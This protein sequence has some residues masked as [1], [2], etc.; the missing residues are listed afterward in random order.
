MLRLFR[1][2][3]YSDKDVVD[4]DSAA[5]LSQVLRSLRL[6]FAE[7]RDATASD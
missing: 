2:V 6:A 3:E 5:E 1:D 7:A 4:R